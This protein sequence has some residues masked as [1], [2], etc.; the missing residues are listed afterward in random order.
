MFTTIFFI[1]KFKNFLVHHIDM[2]KISIGLTLINNYF[3]ISVFNQT[4]LAI[5]GS[6]THIKLFLHVRFIFGIE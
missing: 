6:V 2:K 5:K 1:T 4:Y 3:E